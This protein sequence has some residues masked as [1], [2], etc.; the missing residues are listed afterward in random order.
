MDEPVLHRNTRRARRALAALMLALLCL[1]ASACDSAAA[2][3]GS[4]PRPQ[5]D[6]SRTFESAPAAGDSQSTAI[7]ADD[8]P[9]YQGE[10]SVTLNG[11]MPS[12]TAEELQLPTFEEYAPLDSLGR[13]GAA[14]AMVSDETRPAA[15]EKRGSISYIHPTGWEQGRYPFINGESLYNRSHL[16][17]WSLGAENDNPR[18]LITGTTYMNQGTMQL[19]ENRILG[20]IRNTGNHA[21]V[22]VTPWFEGDDL[23]ARGV[24][25]EAYSVEDQGRSVC[26]N[27]F[28]FNVQPGVLIDYATGANQADGEDAADAPAT[29]APAAGDGAS[30]AQGQDASASVAGAYGSGYC[31]QDGSHHSEGHHGYQGGTGNGA[32]A[33]AATADGT[34]QAQEYVLNTNT[35]KIH[36]PG[37]SSVSRMAEHNRQHCTGTVAD[38]CAQGYSPCQVCWPE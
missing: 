22:R 15:N 18:N 16:I 19:V 1:T 9:E 31:Y 28:M 2:A 6:S 26:V 35:M 5:A 17:A 34:A 29:D 7:S 4:A 33:G 13:C 21:L 14:F 23:L 30:D 10:A 24:Q 32:V 25:Y 12:F 8:L 11:G 20:Y 3:N 37:C 27:E 38:L 36:R